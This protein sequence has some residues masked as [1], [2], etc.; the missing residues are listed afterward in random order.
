LQNGKLYVT[1]GVVG[2]RVSG[3]GALGL[4][5]ESLSVRLAHTELGE[6]FS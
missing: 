5:L 4:P 6:C 3:G 1:V 2:A